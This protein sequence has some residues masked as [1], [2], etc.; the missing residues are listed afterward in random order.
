MREGTMKTGSTVIGLRAVW[1]RAASL[2]LLAFAFGCASQSGPNAPRE[3]TS[4]GRR[5]QPDALPKISIDRDLSNV[6]NGRVLDMAISQS[7]RS[8]GN[9]GPFEM[10]RGAIERALDDHLRGFT[11]ATA[12]EQRIWLADIRQAFQRTSIRT[13]FQSDE[14][15]RLEVWASGRVPSL[16]DAYRRVYLTRCATL[17]RFLAGYHL[18]PDGGNLFDGRLVRAWVRYLR[19]ADGSTGEQAAGSI[20]RLVDNEFGRFRDEFDGLPLSKQQWVLTEWRNRIEARK[21]N[22]VSASSVSELGV[23]RPTADALN[24]WIERQA[25]TLHF[26]LARIYV[27]RLCGALPTD[28][29]CR[30]VQLYSTDRIRHEAII[31]WNARN[32][33]L[34]K[35]LG[36]ATVSI[37]DKPETAVTTWLSA[38]ATRARRTPRTATPQQLQTI[39]KILLSDYRRLLSQEQQ[40]A[41]FTM[42]VLGHRLSQQEQKQLAYFLRVCA[43]DA[44]RSKS[45]QARLPAPLSV[46]PLFLLQVSPVQ[47]PDAPSSAYTLTF[48]NGQTLVASSSQLRGFC[49][50]VE[51]GRELSLGTNCQQLNAVN[52]QLAGLQGQIA[53]LE[54]KY[55]ARTDVI[56]RVQDTTAFIAQQ[57]SEWENAGTYKVLGGAAEITSASADAVIDAFAP[58]PFKEGYSLSTAVITDVSRYNSGHVPTDVAINQLQNYAEQSADKFPLFHD[59]GALS[60]IVVPLKEAVNGAKDIA[61]GLEDKDQIRE[62]LDSTLQQNN[63]LLQG[64]KDKQMAD[65]N[66]LLQLYGQ[67]E[68]LEWRAD[69]LKLG[70]DPDA[71]DLDYSLRSQVPALDDQVQADQRDSQAMDIGLRNITAQDLTKDDPGATTDYRN[72]TEGQRDDWQPLPY[73]PPADAL[74]DDTG[75]VQVAFPDVL[76]LSLP[77]PVAVE[78]PEIGDDPQR[79]MTDSQLNDAYNNDLWTSAVNASHAGGSDDSL[80]NL[81]TVNQ[82]ALEEFSRQLDTINRDTAKDMVNIEQRWQRQLEQAGSAQSLTDNLRRAAAIQNSKVSADVNDHAA[83]VGPGGHPCSYYLQMAQQYR[84]AA[85]QNHSYGLQVAQQHPAAAFQRQADDGETQSGYYEQAAQI[86]LSAAQQYEAEYQKCQGQQ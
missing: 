75:V 60:E 52:N 54:Q 3:V 22:F 21:P 72:I 15:R 85:A 49:D 34:L 44:T 30:I 48:A 68:D 78:P 56:G 80:Q 76:K 24:F 1:L 73:V 5:V 11:A 31:R 40:N 64:L 42:R 45:G 10:A 46:R 41:Y 23:S 47:Q 39:S 74:L 69:M 14:A 2:V 71:A 28:A 26:E 67:Q 62:A 58:A 37:A 33:R 25:V 19:D 61:E 65:S 83:T 29:V 63:Q 20:Q 12:S 55:N 9:A 82:D 86:D 59:T 27:S 66:Q 43:I 8:G 77:S 57:G 6:A 81:G 38:A 53:S 7:A 51:T 18:H 79:E 17:D 70:R 35:A 4:S 50:A 84:A 16:P 13:R 36:V 32:K